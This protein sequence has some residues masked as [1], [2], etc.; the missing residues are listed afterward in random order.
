MNYAKALLLAS[1]V[2]FVQPALAEPNPNFTGIWAREDGNARVRIAPCGDKVC[3]TNVWIGDTSKGEEPGDRLIMDLKPKSGNSM[4]G[5]AYDPKREMTYAITV[6]V[7]DGA[8]TT[9]G[10]IVGGL[11]CRNV[12]WKPAQ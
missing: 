3:A 11:L 12:G 1:G 10:C 2:A 9:R 6:T 7:A 8:L 4:S 5:T